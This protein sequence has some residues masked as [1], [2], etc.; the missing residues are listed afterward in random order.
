MKK[1]IRQA[2]KERILVLDGAMG[3][4]IQRANLK[5]EDFGNPELDGCNENLVITRPD[6][7]GNIHRQYLE[8]GA[9]IIETNTFGGTATVLAEYGL[10]ENIREI[11][12]AAVKVAKQAAEEFSTDEKPRYVAGS[13]GP[14]TKSLSI[15]GGITFD[16][17]SDD[18]YTQS[19]LLIEGGVDY[20]LFETSPDTLN[21]KAALL[22]ME[23][24]VAESGKD[25][26]VALS[27]TIEQTGTMLAG[28]TVGALVS[29]VENHD[30][31]YIGLNCALGPDQMEKYAIQMSQASPFASACV[32]NAGM[33]NADGSYSQTPDVFSATVKGFIDKQL[34]NI[35]GGCCGTSPDH[36][37]LIAEFAKTG[38]PRVPT[39]KKSSLLSGITVLDVDQQPRPIIV[40]ER[41]N[42]IGSRMFKNMIIEEKFDEASDLGRKQ[43]RAGAQIID[44]CLANPD[45]DEK[46]DMERFMDF[47]VKKIKVPIMIDTTDPEVLEAALKYCQGKAI[48]NSINLENGLERFEQI[49]PLAKKYGAAL[50]VGCID[51][52]PEHG[53]AVSRERK[54]EV[55]KRSHEILTKDYGI[56]DEDIY[57]D[58]LVFP[59][60]TGDENYKS[61]AVET[62][63]GIRLIKNQFPRCKTALGLSNVSFGLPPAGR[64]VLNAVFLHLNVEAG[65][66]L[67]IANAARTL[68][69][70]EVS[71]QHRKMAED[72]IFQRGDDPISAFAAEF[73]DKKLTK[74]VDTTNMSLP[75]RLAN[76][77]IEGSKDGLATDLD[78][79]VKANNQAPIDVIN[80]PLMKGMGVVGKKFNNNEL[81]VA[82]VLQ[83]AEAMRASVN[84]LEQ[85]MDS[86]DSAKKGKIMLATVKGD[87][88]DIG[89]NLVDIILSNNGYEVVNIGIKCVSEHIIQECRKHNPDV[90]GLSGLLVKSA[91]QMVATAKDL[92]EAGI[93]IPIVVGG[94][95]LSQQF[96]T[97]KIA[98]AY[99]GKV[100]YAKDAMFGLELSNRIVLG[101]MADSQPET[102]QQAQGVQPAAE[103][104]SEPMDTP[105]ITLMP[106]LVPAVNDFGVHNIPDVS[107]DTLFAG[108]NKQTVLERYLGFANMPEGKG[109]KIKQIKDVLDAMLERIKREKLLKPEGVVRFMQ[110]DTTDDTLNLYAPDG[111]KASFGFSAVENGLCMTDFVLPQGVGTDCVALFAV[112]TGAGIEELTAEFNAKG[113]YLNGHILQAVAVEAVEAL[114]DQVQLYI[115]SQWKIDHRSTRVSIGYEGCPG[116]EAH[117]GLFDLLE[118]EKRTSITLTESFMM[119]PQASVSAMVFHHPQSELFLS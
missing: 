92:T 27:I 118:V 67:A 20:L 8:A 102:E 64:E 58:A 113:E 76:Y 94:A 116:L 119:K 3:T 15:T 73:R 2:L 39:V 26:P 1:P 11:N 18:F 45:R 28:H 35:V 48:I 10:Q 115:N 110:A 24:A 71:E 91:H 40:G 54:L 4:M 25:I 52:D 69:I 83:S 37:K 66:D 106:S 47:L 31:L 42:V 6:V 109:E 103:T 100:Y 112:S 30:L 89:K 98:P 53:M 32:P 33:P 97:E 63:E 59:L 22:G 29:A 56:A 77:I 34:V 55:A 111:T 105:E 65:M 7:I 88:H 60:A 79:A 72:M 74:K 96:V 114:A 70:E 41:T 101:D 86:A 46:A 90:L 75:E 23:K 57:F 99:G 38:I 87:V 49:V 80:G 36:I 84:H 104:E 62:I 19:V 82:E 107:I 108:I 13:L 17:L 14:T 43:V 93:T 16:E 117:K 81:I 68:S 9:D 21:V 5:P 50:V 61:S 95:A 51:E 78:E 85:Y 44:V 12:L